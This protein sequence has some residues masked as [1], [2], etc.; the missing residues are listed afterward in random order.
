MLTLKKLK[1]MKP[2]T[3]FAQGIGLIEHPW[4]NDATR[5]LELDGRSTKVKW[6]AIR[7]YYHD[8]AIYHSLDSNL[9]PANYLDGIQ[10]LEADWQT[11]ADHGA[12][13]HNRNI[14]K[15]LVPCSKLALQ[16]YRD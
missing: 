15:K 4:F 1:A 7:G 12:K 13:L 6:V 14:V 9:E 10:H 5:T 8:W 3:I 11:I 16:F 2:D